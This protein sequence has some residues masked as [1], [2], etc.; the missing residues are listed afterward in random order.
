M[1]FITCFAVILFSSNMYLPCILCLS[2][3]AQRHTVVNLCVCSSVCLYEC[4]Y[5]TLQLRFLEASSKLSA[6]MFC[7]GTM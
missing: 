2:E 7:V 1:L 6:D 5:V 3:H 4:M